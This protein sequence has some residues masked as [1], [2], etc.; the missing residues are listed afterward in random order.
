HSEQNGS[1]TEP[2]RF[3]QMWIMPRERG[4]TP[5]VEQKVF[6]KEDR[7]DGLLKVISGE[8]GD[9][10]LVYQD[11]NVYVSSLGAGVRLEH[12]LEPGRGEYLYVIEGALRV[13]E[14]K[15]ATGDAA[16]IWEE[17]RITLEPGEPSELIMVEVRLS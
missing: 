7:T 3:I 8:G 13:N 2:M 17:A 15:M 4:L 14:E 5:G 11:A 10:V 6:T 1:E 16:Q 9:A 12:A